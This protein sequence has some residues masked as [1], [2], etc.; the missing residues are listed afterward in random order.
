M[1]NRDFSSVTPSDTVSSAGTAATWLPVCRAL[2]VAIAAETAAGSAT[3]SAATREAPSVVSCDSM[4]ADA[5]GGT[6]H[7]TLTRPDVADAD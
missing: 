5:V 7:C 4:V 2:T 3:V 6:C 1:L